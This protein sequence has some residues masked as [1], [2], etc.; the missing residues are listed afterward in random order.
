[1][2]KSLLVDKKALE[3]SA[4]LVEGM[5]KLK[6]MGLLSGKGLAQVKLPG[7][8]KHHYVYNDYHAKS[9]N[10]GYSRNY[11]GKFYTK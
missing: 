3:K 11:Q 6:E 2:V 1:M 8:I 10:P 5:K 7:V 9:T 4:M